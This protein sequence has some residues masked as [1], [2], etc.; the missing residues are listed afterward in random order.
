[1]QITVESPPMKK[2]TLGEKIRTARLALDKTQG[3]FAAS[4][5]LHGK[6]A[7]AYISRA[8]LGKLE[9]RLSTLRIMEKKLRLPAGGLTD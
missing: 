7:A 1:M 3:E 9:P 2:L 6:G 4:L 8:E 5:G